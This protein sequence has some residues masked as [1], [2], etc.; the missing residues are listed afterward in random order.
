MMAVGGTVIRF[1]TSQVFRFRFLK[2]S[3]ERAR[4]GDG[5]GGGCRGLFNGNM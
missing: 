5:E 2:K 4:E 1:T 3:N